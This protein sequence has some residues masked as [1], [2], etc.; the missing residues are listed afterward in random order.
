M[1]HRTTITIL[2]LLTL[3]TPQ[4]PAQDAEDDEPRFEVRGRIVQQAPRTVRVSFD[5]YERD[6]RLLFGPQPTEKQ[7]RAFAADGGSLVV[8]MR[9]DEEMD[10]LGFDERAL[11]A[12]LG[13]DYAHIPVSTGTVTF[14]EAR[15][16][17]ETL[18]ATGGAAMLHCKTGSRAAMLYG[19]HLA[20]I[21]ATTKDQAKSRAID[22]GMSPRSSPAFDRVLM[23]VPQRVVGRVDPARLIDNVHMLASFGTRHTLSET[24]D[25]H[26]G[27]GAARRW[28]RG[29]FER[30]IE[31]NGK[32]GDA[33]P[34]VAFDA[35]TVEPD[36]R[37]ITREVEVV[38]V[39]CTLPGSSP[40]ARDRVHYVLAHLDSR[41][42]DANDA[43]SDAP[44]ANDDASG[45]AALIELARVLAPENL[46]A[47]IVLMATSGEE[48]GL[49]GAR[50]HAR[51]LA[52]RGVRV[53]AV[54]NNDTIG[55]PDGT[56]GRSA[57]DEVR[58][59]SEG[60]PAQ[61]LS[62]GSPD[63]LTNAL[64]R[65]RLYGSESDSPSRQLAR[66]TAFIGDLHAT[67]PVKPR[68]IFRPD[69]YL[70]GGDHTPFNELGFPAVRFCEVHED[71]TKQHQDVRI[72][73]GV[74]FGD[75]ARAVDP[76]YLAGVTKLNAA[77]LVHLANAPGVPSN[78]RILVAELSTDTTLRWDAS[79]GPDVAG[80]EI[81]WRATTDPTWTRMKDVGDTTEATID[82]S[83]DNWVFGVRA[84]DTQG[85]RS[86]AAFPIA[87]RE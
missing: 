44:G 28:V 36:G 69:R 47:T 20:S 79:E 57:P 72:E 39:V 61:L 23:K 19:L 11:C 40:E 33:A 21:G 70:R 1:T 17:R 18:R 12:E 85:Y 66:Y 16:L 22:L 31:G 34:S 74:Q 67:L 77:T 49:F 30:A 86:M 7:I 68:L 15:T 5:E 52:D 35:H 9:T 87:A 53:A 38:N 6:G 76:P 78:A 2:V 71:Y 3:A 63:R 45:V 8:S 80:Y 13:L 51:D 75:L 81:V 60:L 4:A 56:D 10:A 54:L 64:Y 62:A 82:L 65:L 73:D 25:P 59:F 27:I 83:K 32:A 37:R 42:T 48:Q 29:A 24:E 14:D 84:Y 41:A 58:V 43:E 26:R 46:D 50:L 55:D